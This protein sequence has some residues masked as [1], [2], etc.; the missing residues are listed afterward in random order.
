MFNIFSFTIRK[1]LGTDVCKMAFVW[2]WPASFRKIKTIYPE[3]FEMKVYSF[4][5]F[6]YNKSAYH[7]HNT[8]I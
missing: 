1:H 2:V 7:S 3:S 5:F 8:I 6:G 4:L